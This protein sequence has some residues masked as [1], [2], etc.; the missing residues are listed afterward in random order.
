MEDHKDDEPSM[1]ETDNEGRSMQIVAEDID[2]QSLPQ[3]DTSRDASEEEFMHSRDHT[4]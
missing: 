3:G 2:D 1:T 4:G